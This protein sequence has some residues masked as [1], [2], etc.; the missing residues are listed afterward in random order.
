M[1]VLPARIPIFSV[2]INE[3]GERVGRFA[4]GIDRLVGE[5]FRFGR[6]VIRRVFTS[7][8]HQVW[9][10]DVDTKTLCLYDNIFSA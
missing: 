2:V 8:G 5:E 10:G 4:W 6:H 1:T 3:N 7:R 9:K